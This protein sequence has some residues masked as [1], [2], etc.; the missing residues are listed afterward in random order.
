MWLTNRART[1]RKH[2]TPEEMRVW[3][4]LRDRRFTG[5][6][7]RRQKPLGNSIADFYCAEIGLVIELDGRGTKHPRKMPTTWGV[8]ANCRRWA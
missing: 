8:I 2:S 4:W 7:F 6:K 3:R 5:L 1:L